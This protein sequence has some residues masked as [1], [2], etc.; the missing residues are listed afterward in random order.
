MC[1]AP[2]YVYFGPIGDIS[3]KHFHILS[4]ARGDKPPSRA[5]LRRPISY[6]FS[7]RSVESYRK[8]GDRTYGF[9]SQTSQIAACSHLFCKHATIAFKMLYPRP[10]NMVTA[11][12]RKRAL[13]WLRLP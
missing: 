8:A 5:Q 4:S 12:A 2:A 9:Y 10:S 6:S 11:G 7:A 1:S 13:P 3:A